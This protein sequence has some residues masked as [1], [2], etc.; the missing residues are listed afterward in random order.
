M[1]IIRWDGWKAF[2]LKDYPLGWLKSVF[3]GGL[4]VGMVVRRFYLRIIS[5][6]GWKAFLLEDYQVGAGCKAF[7]IKDNQV[8][9]L[10]GVFT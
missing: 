10:E 8:G 4:S 5:W 1:R 2:L 3:I 9:W 6:A 7:F